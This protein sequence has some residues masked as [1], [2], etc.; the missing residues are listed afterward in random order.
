MNTNELQK[1]IIQAQNNL[2]NVNQ[3]I[4]IHN[5]ITQ[6]L[7]GILIILLTSFVLKKLIRS[8][9]HN[10]FTPQMSLLKNKINSL[11]KI[12]KI[13]FIIVSALIVAL[14]VG[15]FFSET[16]YY[17]TSTE[18][19]NGIR[20]SEQEYNDITK[21]GDYAYVI[22]KFNF[23]YLLFYSSF[24]IFS[25]ILY[26]LLRNKGINQGSNLLQE[27]QNTAIPMIVNGYRKIA[28]ERNCAPTGKTTDR[29]IIEVYQQVL[30]A[31]NIASHK[32]NENI[33][34]GNLNFIALKFFQVYETTGKEA[35]NDHLA[36]EVDKYLSEGLRPEY[37]QTLEVL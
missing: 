3:Q 16:L 34:A 33:P 26:L 35:F 11:G 25:G 36:Y 21:D 27:S 37:N 14:T 9:I 1:L 8:K 13:I 19:A 12:E 15:Y 4:E 2:A 31:F 32:K 20:I 24:I 29:E 22:T 7:I 5:T 17:S 18:F 30:T 10:K 23:N 28:L 6:Y